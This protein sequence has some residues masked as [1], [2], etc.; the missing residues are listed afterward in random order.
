MV[1]SK[2]KSRNHPLEGYIKRLIA[3]GALLPETPE[4]V[5]EVVGI[6]QEL[7]H[8]FGCLFTQS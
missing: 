6:P 1:I 4:N 2:K 5:Q 8:C 3:G 7:W